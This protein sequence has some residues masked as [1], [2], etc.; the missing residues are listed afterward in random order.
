MKYL[1]S[2]GLENYINQYTSQELDVLSV[3]PLGTDSLRNIYT[4][5]KMDRI[6]SG[7]K[8]T[9]DYEIFTIT[10][11][12]ASYLAVFEKNEDYVYWAGTGFSIHYYT[13]GKWHLLE[14]KSI[15]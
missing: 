6:L 5:E 12:K 15:K 11:N 10:Y 14:C 1:K 4:I 7:K 9:Y 13:N 8:V 2:R 3:L